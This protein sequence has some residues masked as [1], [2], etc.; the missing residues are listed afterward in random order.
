MSGGMAGSRQ[1]SSGKKFKKFPC[2]H[3]LRRKNQKILYGL[4]LAPY[5]P[6]P[7]RLSS[8]LASQKLILAGLGIKNLYHLWY[9]VISQGKN[10][11]R[12]AQC[13]MS[14]FLDICQIKNQKSKSNFIFVLI[15][16]KFLLRKMPMFLFRWANLYLA[17]WRKGSIVLYV[18]ALFPIA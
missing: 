6:S 9:T 18:A 2:N 1:N 13:P 8:D 14:E 16:D 3:P 4:F 7:M 17:E 11:G 12:V 10:Q 15:S 5:F